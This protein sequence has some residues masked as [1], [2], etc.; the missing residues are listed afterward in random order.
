MRETAEMKVGAWRVGVGN[1]E[2]SIDLIKQALPGRAEVNQ[3]GAGRFEVTT[4]ASHPVFTNGSGCYTRTLPD[5]TEVGF[6]REPPIR[7][8]P[9]GRPVRWLEAL[10]P[11]DTFVIR[12]SDKSEHAT[13]LLL[14]DENP[15]DPTPVSRE[16]GFA[17]MLVELA[18]LVKVGRWFR[19]E[20]RDSLGSRLVYLSD[21]LHEV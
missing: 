18:N 11:G 8:T 21:R 17:P 3:V 4:A 1:F 20:V 9:E 7:L 10:R 19:V 6:Y 16:T 2:P 14:R 5:G 13:W 15:L 12:P